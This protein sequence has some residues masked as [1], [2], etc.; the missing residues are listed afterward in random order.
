MLVYTLFKIKSVPFISR[1]LYLNWFLVI[2]KGNSVILHLQFLSLFL[3]KE[4]ANIMMFCCASFG[5]D[6]CEPMK[7]VKHIKS[8]YPS[9]VSGK[10]IQCWINWSKKKIFRNWCRAMK[11]TYP[12]ASKQEDTNCSNK[13]EVSRQNWQKLTPQKIYSI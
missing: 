5:T 8:S 6:H 7:S 3:L 10:K 1:K 4:N 2:K 12:I 13:I 11:N 9:C